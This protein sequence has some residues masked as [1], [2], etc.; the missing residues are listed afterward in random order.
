MKK[1]V[2]IIQSRL[3]RRGLKGISEVEIKNVILNRVPNVES[4]FTEEQKQAVVSELLTKYE[5]PGQIAPSATSNLASSN[6][7]VASSL[8]DRV[9][10]D[11]TQQ[12]QAFA[13]GG[14]T[15]IAQL[16]KELGSSFTEDDFL[17]LRQLACLLSTDV[18]DT[19][20]LVNS[21]ITAYLHKRHSVLNAAL[22]QLERGRKA[23][24]EEMYG[25]L[26]SDFFQARSQQWEQFGSQMLG[27][28][29]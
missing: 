20:S 15:T 25:G 29:N 27:L 26:D 3:A 19:E 23:Q 11:T 18:K 12:T 8:D 4:E 17:E 14:S 22:T 13:S 9:V 10:D 1:S 6:T 2:K 16:V 21:L 5:T 7:E 24:N 28:F